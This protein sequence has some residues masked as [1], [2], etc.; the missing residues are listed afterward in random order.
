MTGY[1]ATFN[2][3]NSNF[4]M[5]QA[6]EF[7]EWVTSIV[8]AGAEHYSSPQILKYHSILSL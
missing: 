8:N 1:T 4:M 2:K 5:I 3:G 7:L 6:D